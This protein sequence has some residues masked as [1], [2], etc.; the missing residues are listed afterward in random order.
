MPGFRS[1]G[2]HLSNEIQGWPSSQD[3][4]C[5]VSHES[6]GSSLQ[7]LIISHPA[8]SQLQTVQYCRRTGESLESA[9]VS[10]FDSARS[11]GLLQ[12]SNRPTPLLKSSVIDASRSP[13]LGSLDSAHACA[14]SMYRPLETGR[15]QRHGSGERRWSDAVK[16][17]T[18]GWSTGPNPFRLQA[19]YPFIKGMS[20]PPVRCALR[21]RRPST[22][23][24]STSYSVCAWLH[25]TDV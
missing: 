10:R 4:S 3:L 13:L 6:R 8:V 21:D 20:R 19:A 1:N 16:L 22:A 15:M 14:S 23:H 5:A 17:A 24:G 11:R 2:N 25:D 9:P 7:L 12:A 18:G